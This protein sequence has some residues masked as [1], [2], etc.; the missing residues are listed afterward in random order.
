MTQ[1][2]LAQR[3]ARRSPSSPGWKAGERARRCGRWSVWRTQPD[4][5]AYQL[6]AARREEARKVTK[7]VIPRSPGFGGNQVGSRRSAGL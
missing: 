7:E 3:W 6:R 1:E 2:A 5:V 4:R